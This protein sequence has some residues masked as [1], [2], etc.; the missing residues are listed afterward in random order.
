M[1]SQRLSEWWDLPTQCENGHPW[2]PG[3]VIVSWQGC[4]YSL[5]PF[6]G[7]RVARCRTEG[8]GSVWY[9]PPHDATPAD[10]SDETD[11]TVC[12]YNARHTTDGIPATRILDYGPDDFTPACDECAASWEQGALKRRQPPAAR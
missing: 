1:N 8:C 9:D 4:C 7:H 6:A 2:G 12:H 3:R 10:D 5:E 11:L